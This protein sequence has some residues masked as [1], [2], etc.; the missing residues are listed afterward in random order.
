MAD[1]NGSLYTLIGKKIKKL[2]VHSN[3]NQELL[4][5][6]VGIGR[7]SVSN[8]E[9]GRH[10]AP[11]HIIYRICKELE[12]DIHSIMPTLTEIN[13]MM[14]ES[15]DGLI[16]RLNKVNLPNK[17]KKSIESYFQQITTL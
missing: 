13:E 4:A 3:V 8:I 2:R 17:S 1:F 14:K 11:L 7:T 10:H 12:S 15:E 6:K 16:S 9:L 5:K